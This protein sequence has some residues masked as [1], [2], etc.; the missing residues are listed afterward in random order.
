MQYTFVSAALNIKLSLTY[1]RHL[2]GGPTEK[3]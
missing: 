3:T 2:E 1:K